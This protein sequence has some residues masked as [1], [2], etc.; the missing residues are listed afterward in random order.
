MRARSR[1]MTVQT[2]IQILGLALVVYLFARIFL[3][4]VAPDKARA[5]VESGASLVDVRTPDEFAS[6]HIQGAVNIP[7]SDLARRLSELG[8]KHSPVVVYCASGMRS[9]SAKSMLRRAGF[10]E[11][12][13]LG[14]MRRWASPAPSSS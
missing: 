4:K 11:V 1:P 5:L 9:A 14:A 6:G 10:V 8:Q 3:G 7:L 2:V 12:H 13:D